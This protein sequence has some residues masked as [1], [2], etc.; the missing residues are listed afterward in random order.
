MVSGDV[1]HKKAAMC[2]TQK[3]HVKQGSFRPNYTSLG[4]SSMLMCPQY[5]YEKASFKRNAHKT[6]P[7]IDGLAKCCYQQLTET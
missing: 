7:C 2:L 5:V 4:E 3:M 6:R 1:K